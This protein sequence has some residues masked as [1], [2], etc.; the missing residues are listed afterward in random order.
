[1][2]ANQLNTLH[3]IVKE[4]STPRDYDWWILGIASAIFDFLF[5]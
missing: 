3:N 4:L 5:F 2:Y 1:M